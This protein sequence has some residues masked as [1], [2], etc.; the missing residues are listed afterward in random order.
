MKKDPVA[1]L[2]LSEET[3]IAG[4]PLMNAHPAQ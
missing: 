3:L 2:A 1:G 4:I